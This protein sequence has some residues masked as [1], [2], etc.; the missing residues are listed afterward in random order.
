MIL[1]LPKEYHVRA[2]F[3]AATDTY[4]EEGEITHT[5]PTASLSREAIEAI[6][7]KYR[8]EILQKPP[9]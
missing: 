6:L 2:T 4:D 9:L 7:P 3:G 1:F 8:G 5:A